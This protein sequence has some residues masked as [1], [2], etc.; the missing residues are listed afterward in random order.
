MAL[1]YPSLCV[2][3]RTAYN[4]LLQ[5]LCPIRDDLVAKV[6]ELDGWVPK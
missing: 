2:F 6:A 5:E 1:L 3:R 4:S